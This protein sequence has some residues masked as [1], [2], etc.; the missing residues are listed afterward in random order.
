MLIGKGVPKHEILFCL[1][2]YYGLPFVEYD[3]SIIT[4]YL[5]IIR[6]DM[7]KLKQSLWFPRSIR[8]DRAEV[9]AYRPDDPRV[10]D[11]IKKTLGVH[12]I[13]FIVALPAD[14]VRIIE[15]NFDVNPSFSFSGRKNAP[16]A[17]EDLFRLP[18]INLCSLQDV[19]RQGKDRPC[20]YQDRRLLHRYCPFVPESVRHRSF[21]RLRGAA[22]YRRHYHVSMT[23]SNG[24]SRR[25]E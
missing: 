5:L 4:A 21:Y 11:D 17:S 15:H 25:E 8:Q 22:P 10:I 12:H 24:I 14:I 13:D 2:E 7:E 20:V 1:S 18:A 16:C 9:I 3:E 6:L 19:I 23:D